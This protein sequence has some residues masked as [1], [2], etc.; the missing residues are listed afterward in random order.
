MADSPQP[1]ALVTGATS[2]IGVAVA[3]RL[4]EDGYT[5]AGL[6]IAAPPGLLPDG[7]G[8]EDGLFSA[9]WVG[10]LTD[11]LGTTQA[12]ASMFADTPP[13]VLVHCA[14]WTPFGKFLDSSPETDD[15]VLDVN[16]A[17]ML[18]VVRPMLRS[19]VAAESG[20]IVLISSDAARVG[21]YGEAVY[22]GAKAAQIA[23]A[24]SVAVEVA[25]TGV[26][27]N[28]VCPGTTDTPLLHKMFTEKQIEKR[29]RANPM[30][31]IA[32][33]DDVANAVEFF[34]RPDS[35]Y[36]TGQVIS[37]NGGLNRVD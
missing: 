4:R 27:L 14:G 20:R 5:V 28:V 25:R 9:F 18:N 2:G 1:V 24:K 11:R 33:A 13:A 7:R 37:V 22:A 21:V 35:S 10:D 12:L 34:T 29:L 19:M 31:R 30:R 36:V 15:R 26:T 16:L 17:G 32:T 23:F 8:T 6:D 3:R